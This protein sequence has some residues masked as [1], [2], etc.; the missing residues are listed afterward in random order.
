MLVLVLVLVLVLALYWSDLHT[1]TNADQG[2]VLEVRPYKHRETPCTSTAK[3]SAPAPPLDTLYR[4]TPCTRTPRHTYSVN[5]LHQRSRSNSAKASIS[6]RVSQSFVSCGSQ[7][8]SEDVLQ[9]RRSH[10]SAT[11]YSIISH[12]VRGAKMLTILD[13]EPPPLSPAHTH[14][15]VYHCDC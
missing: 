14:T 10:V 1:A 2:G 15:P 11:H 13:T 9:T 12:G 4:E 3:H 6:G 5:K 7:T 8:G